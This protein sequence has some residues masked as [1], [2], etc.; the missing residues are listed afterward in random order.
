MD[1]DIIKMGLLFIPV[2][3]ILNKNIEFIN[4]YAKGYL[5]TSVLFLGILN[6]ILSIYF[7]NEG[8]GI[9]FI[10]LWW[11]F[12]VGSLVI[13]L[14]MYRNSKDYNESKKY[15]IIDKVDTICSIIFGIIILM[16]PYIYIGKLSIFSMI[17]GNVNYIIDIVSKVLFTIAGLSWIILNHDFGRKL[18]KT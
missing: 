8:F 9:G 1:L 15:T 11:I 10:A 2:E 6:I 12:I 18:N 4:I 17:G 13:N 7:A 3:I 14:L 5:R 16:T